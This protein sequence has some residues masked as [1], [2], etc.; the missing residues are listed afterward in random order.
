MPSIKNRIVSLLILI[1]SWLCF[2]G[3]LEF[4]FWHQTHLLSFSSLV[5][6]LTLSGSCLIYGNFFTRKTQLP[7]T[8]QDQKPFQLVLGFFVFNTLLFLITILGSLK[9]VTSFWIL[10]TGGLVIMSK[11]LLKSENTYSFSPLKK[12]LPGL[13]CF[14]LSG[15][16]ATLWCH[17]ALSLPVN[18]GHTFFFPIWQDSFLHARLI[19]IFAQ[20]DGIH[21]LSNLCMKD[22]PMGLYHY[23]SYLIPAVTVSVTH[24][25][26][27][28]I[29]S[30]F[31]VPVGI[32]LSGLAAFSLATSLWGAWPGLAAIL[33]VV[34]LPDAYQQ[35]FQ[36]KFLSYH[37]LQQVGPAGLYG[38]ACVAVAWIF[39]LEGCREKKLPLLVLGYVF[40]AITVIYKAQLFVANAFL[41][42][43]YPCFFFLQC[44]TRWRLLA[45]LLLTLLF[46]SVIAISQHSSSIPIIRF[47]GSS[48]HRYATMLSNCITPGRLHDFLLEKFVT[49][50]FRSPCY[51]IGAAMMIFFCTLG[52]WGPLWIITTFFLRRKADLLTLLFPLVIIINYLIMS[53]GLAF[54]TKHIG[55]PEEL[56]HRP[57]VWAYFAV[58]AWTAGG[59]YFLFFENRFPKS[60]LSR[61][62]CLLILLASFTTPLFFA[63]GLQTMPAWGKTLTSNAVPVDMMKAIH[64]IRNH[65]SSFE[66][67]QDSEGD[68][69]FI[70]TALTERQAYAISPSELNVNSS[71]ALATRAQELEVFKKM[72]S[73]EGLFSFLQTHSIKW[74]LLRPET[75]VAWPDSF[76]NKVA[77]VSGGYRVYHWTDH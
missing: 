12:D 38:T 2:S 60:L 4:W 71:P 45:A 42:L 5:I 67:L 40:L 64:F 74:Y 39:I 1:F 21:I 55:M 41:I 75:N 35:G 56:V 65:S 76:K 7:S 32:F 13:L 20:A 63:H 8:L 68:P 58:T 73:E 48:L 62:I 22:F 6:S 77:F 24:A 44:R 54:D 16:G 46:C 18:D 61:V 27:Y 72:K 23:G 69:C 10:V 53:L 59:L 49:Y 66:T 14:I 25:T 11:T 9:V 26:A 50:P 36:N 51:Q 33:A 52:I 57:F 37:F 30:C 28:E 17:D 31:L 15:L 70:V 19:S 3:F 47:D 29:F 34:F 43:I